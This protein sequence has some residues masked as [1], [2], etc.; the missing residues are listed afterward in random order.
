M[1]R[2][3]LAYTTNS[4]S[5]LSMHDLHLIFNQLPRGKEM[6]MDGKK[7][8]LIWVVNYL[9]DSEFSLRVLAER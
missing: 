2:N 1:I 7:K 9:V 8:M 5:S 6:R 3:L 4:F